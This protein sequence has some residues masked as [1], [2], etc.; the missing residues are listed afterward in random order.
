MA[1]ILHALNLSQY[2][3]PL[4]AMNFKTAYLV[5]IIWNKRWALPAFSQDVFFSY[6]IQYLPYAGSRKGKNIKEKKHPVS[7]AIGQIMLC[8]LVSLTVN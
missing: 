6:P 5:Y 7:A 4:F 2:Q 3:W 1:T 8:I